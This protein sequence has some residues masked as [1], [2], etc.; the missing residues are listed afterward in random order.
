MLFFVNLLG[1]KQGILV[2][3]S[4]FSINGLKASGFALAG[5]T[6][7][8]L[9]DT[10]MKAVGA[11]L[12]PAWEV[13]GF[14]GFFIC[15][16]LF[17]SAVVRREPALLWPKSPARQLLRSALDLGNNICVVIALRHLPLALFYIL[18]FL[19]PLT[20]VLFA[21]IFLREKLPPLKLA[22]IVMGFVGVVVA[23]DP[24]STQRQGDW[25]GYLCCMVCVLCF[26]TNMVWSRV[27][28]RREDPRAMTFFSGLGMVTFGLLMTPA[29]LVGFGMK[30]F[31][32][33]ALMSLFCLLGT[34]FVF[35][36]VKYTAAANV[37]P[38][39]YTQLPTGALVAYLLWHEI[40]TFSMLVGAGLIAGA[41]L[42]IAALAAREERQRGRQQDEPAVALSVAE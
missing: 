41:G 4:S 8:V 25:V 34:L 17:L 30:S 28:T 40:P 10:A 5:F 14:L 19:S 27:L 32:L 26:S 18:V 42:L 31:V 35:F 3:M 6:F 22:A 16:Y 39:H 21:A 24:F 2:Q 38:F 13:I 29:G 37:S 15:F 1:L 11:T 36:A 7:W 23:V 12:L 9:A 20:V 33:M